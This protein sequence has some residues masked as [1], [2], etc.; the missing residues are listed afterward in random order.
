MLFRPDNSK[1]TVSFVLTLMVLVSSVQVMAQQ[2]RQTPKTPTKRVSPVQKPA[3]PPTFDTLLG[4]DCYNI[5]LETRAVGQLISSSSVNELLE[6]ILKLAGPPKEFKTLVRWLNTHAHEVMTSRMLVAAWPVAKNVPEAIV[7]IEFESAEAAAKFEPQLNSFL[8]KV[9]PPTPPDGPGDANPGVT[10]EASRPSFFLTQVGTL[11]LITPSKLTLTKLHPPGSKDL[12]EDANFRTARNRFTSEQLFVYVD[13]AAI[14]KQDQERIKQN[15]EEAKRQAESIA[16]QDASEPK[17]ETSP[18]PADEKVEKEE[19]VPEVPVPESPSSVG[20]PDQSQQKNQPDPFAGLSLLAGSIF[21][22]QPKWPDA[23]GAGISLEGDS[24]EVRAL[25][26]T[27]PGVKASPVPFIGNF[28]TAAPLTPESPG[29]L[30]ADTEL[31]ITASLDLPQIHAAMSNPPTSGRGRFDVQAIKDSEWVSPF[32]GIEK[33]LK[34]NIKDDLLPL[35]GS[36]VAVGIKLETDSGNTTTA[37]PS[38][39]PAPSPSPQSSEMNFVVALSLRDKEGMRVLLPKMVDSLGFKGASAL[40]QTERRGD[41]EL[42]SYGN[43]LAYAFI[44]N[45]LVISGEVGMVRKVVDLYLKNETLAGDTQFKNYTRWQPRQ[46]QGQVYISPALME[47]YKTWANDPTTLISDATREF[48]TRVSTYAQPLTYSL[49]ND[50]FG[51]LHE[52]HV[53]KSLV[54]MAV[55]ALAEGANPPPIV[56]NERGAMG[57]LFMIANAE[58]QYRSDKGNGSFGSVE[59]LRAAGFISD[60][61]LEING[62]KIEIV[63]AGNK[64]AATAVP[65]EYGK[66]GKTSYFV[67]ETKVLRGGDHGGAAASVNDKPIQ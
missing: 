10:T 36:E 19:P 48:L 66:T 13:L 6:P 12:S 33:Q 3:A 67:D 27:A 1:R 8:P 55:A 54:L 61:M 63:A 56:A 53:P 28:I 35:L 44:G 37:S 34:I 46:L 23:I 40:A 41:T 21:T 39:S 7:A 45:F 60:E 17:P 31:L 52:L 59:E 11:I 15:Q 24:L 18:I 20:Q 14:E 51:I 62:Y 38:P 57:A 49:S 65:V 64:F 32:D 58:E 5:Y 25:L 2:R 29:V 42:V 16:K 47:S 30:P 9:L 4:T 26:I 22:G 50:G 43:V